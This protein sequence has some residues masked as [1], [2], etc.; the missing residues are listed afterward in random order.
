MEKILIKPHHFLDI[1]KLYGSGLDSFVPAPDFGHDFY[2]I[3]NI[4]LENP[5]ISMKLTAKGDDIC[6][7]CN[8]FNG[9]V[10]IGDSANNPEY[11]KKEDWNNL[12]DNRLFKKLDLKEGSEITAL[13]FVKLAKEKINKED[14][15]EVWK[16][17]I[18]PQGVPFLL[19]GID[20]YLDKFD[21]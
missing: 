15:L 9:E 4:I 20:K 6:A 1:I 17:K 21:K 8:C 10:C 14:I 11:P 7:P 5:K 2:R 3:G 12:I 19:A 13:E 18:I 16:E